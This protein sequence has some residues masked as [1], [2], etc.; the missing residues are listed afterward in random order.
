ML[1]Q[2]YFWNNWFIEVGGVNPHEPGELCSKLY[3]FVKFNGSHLYVRRVNIWV[4]V[5]C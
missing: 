5:L 2:G 4:K 3:F 1:H